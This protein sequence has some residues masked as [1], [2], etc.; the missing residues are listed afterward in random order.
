MCAW[1]DLFEDNALVDGFIDINDF[2]NRFMWKI[3]QISFKIDSIK[4]KAFK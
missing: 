2:E 4:L 1:Y 3:K